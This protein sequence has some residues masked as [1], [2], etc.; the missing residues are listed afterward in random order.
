MQVI[1]KNKTLGIIT[2][3]VLKVF[4]SLFVPTQAKKGE[5]LNSTMHSVKKTLGLLGDEIDKKS[6]ENESLLTKKS[7]YNKHDVNN[8]NQIF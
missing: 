4:N 5:Q 7:S 3:Q 2:V 6:T 1:S 8:L